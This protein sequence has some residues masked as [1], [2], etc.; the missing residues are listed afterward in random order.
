MPDLEQL[1]KL[2]TAQ[3][4]WGLHPIKVVIALVLPVAILWTADWRIRR[5]SKELARR[6]SA[7]RDAEPMGSGLGG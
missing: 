2:I 3:Y 1:I 5:L 6:D 7:T 4:R